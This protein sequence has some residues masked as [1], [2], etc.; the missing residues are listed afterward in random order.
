MLENQQTK[1]KYLFMKDNNR[2]EHIDLE[3]LEDIYI[4]CKKI[5]NYTNNVT[6][7]DYLKDAKLRDAVENNITRIGEGAA[8]ISDE[9]KKEFDNVEWISIKAVRNRNVHEYRQ[10]QERII[11]DMITQDIPELSIEIEK[12][13]SILRARLNEPN[14]W[15]NYPIIKTYRKEG[16]LII[17]AENE[18]GEITE[19]EFK[20]NSE[21]SKKLKKY[22]DNNIDSQLKK[23]FIKAMEGR[24]RTFLF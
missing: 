8:R 7:T 17:Q 5:I 16:I 20:E 3:K 10:N 4:A 24:E 1:I 23:K 21:T 15:D 11:W 18:Y 13:Y 6:Y 22:G 19:R 12:I 2:K 14:L 9:T